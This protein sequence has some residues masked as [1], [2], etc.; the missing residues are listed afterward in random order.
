VTRREAQRAAEREAEA[1]IA[2][3]EDRGHEF[4]ADVSACCPVALLAGEKW[5]AYHDDLALE[6]E[7]DDGHDDDDQEPDVD[8]S[9]E[10][11]PIEGPGWNDCAEVL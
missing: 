1:T 7:D 2:D 11:E 6:S 5:C 4:P 9:Q 10:W 8:E 3:L